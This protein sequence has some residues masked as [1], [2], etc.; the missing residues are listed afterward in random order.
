[1]EEHLLSLSEVAETLEKSERTIRRWIKSGKLKAYKPGRDYLIPESAIR[2]L[3]E[4]SEVYPKVQA[5]LFPP[6]NVREPQPVTEDVAGPRDGELAEWLRLLSEDEH[7]PLAVGLYPE[8]TMH[9]AS[10]IEG[11]TEARRKVEEAG[12]EPEEVLD[13]LLRHYEFTAQW[14]RRSADEVQEKQ[15]AMTTHLAL[16]RLARQRGLITTEE[17]GRRVE[18]FDVA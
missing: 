1:M 11:M 10:A 8:W 13:F 14:L 4:G 17:L 7:L 3:I 6:D 5:P 18:S 12:F 15:E 16:Q 9:E 2:E